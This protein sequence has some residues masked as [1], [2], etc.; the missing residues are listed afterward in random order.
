MAQEKHKFGKFTSQQH[1]INLAQAIA[2]NIPVCEAS[3]E[4][5]ASTV[6]LYYASMSAMS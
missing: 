1:Q 4:S 5:Q 3:P 2:S 6:D